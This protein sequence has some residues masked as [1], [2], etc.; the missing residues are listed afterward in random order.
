MQDLT[1]GLTKEE[2]QKE[3]IA[4]A[5]NLGISPPEWEEEFGP[6]DNTIWEWPVSGAAVSD[7]A[8][9]TIAPPPRPTGLWDT[10]SDLFSHSLT[11]P[12]SVPSLRP[13]PGPLIE[14][15]PVGAEITVR[16]KNKSWWQRILQRRSEIPTPPGYE[17]EEELDFTPVVHSKGSGDLLWI[18][19]SLLSAAAAGRVA[20][21]E[22]GGGNP[23]AGRLH[24]RSWRP[25]EM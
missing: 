8:T 21:V 19:F 24:A 11:S 12:P 15:P 5:V 3:F 20:G 7:T 6:V 9:E 1:A 4:E 16:P 17:E 10:V 2:A 25:V 23:C 22:C 18:G 13:K 14:G